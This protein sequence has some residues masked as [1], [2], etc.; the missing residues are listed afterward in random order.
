MHFSPRNIEMDILMI[1]V[2]VQ[3][4]KNMECDHENKLLCRELIR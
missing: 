3:Y 4:T 2:H 1:S